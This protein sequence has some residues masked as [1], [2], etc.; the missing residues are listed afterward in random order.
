MFM[1][2]T[3][4]NFLPLFLFHCKADCKA[5]KIGVAVFRALARVDSDKSPERDSSVKDN[6]PTPPQHYK[7][8]NELCEVRVQSMSGM[9][10]SFDESLDSEHPYAPTYEYV[11][12]PRHGESSLYPYL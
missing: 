3:K 1:I 5:G 12:H 6:V 2:R 10:T 4:N 11:S 7:F 9:A 8:H